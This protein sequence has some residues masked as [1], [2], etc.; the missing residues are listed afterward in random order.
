MTIQTSAGIKFSVGPVQTVTEYATNA[1]AVLVL[2]ALIFVEVGEVEDAGEIGDEAATQSFTALNNRR[3]RKVKSTYDAGT[4]TLSLGLDRAD[5][6]QI[7]M[8]A[9][10]KSDSN[11][12]FKIEY[13][14]GECDYYVGQVTT[15]RDSIGG[16]D[17][18]RKASTAIAI[19]SAIFTAAA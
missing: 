15:F 17:A 7:A 8:K 13:I 3:V 10:L 19:N 1:A 16:A 5:A 9:A 6:G 14:D 18:I 4:Q 11:Y 12:A 2:A